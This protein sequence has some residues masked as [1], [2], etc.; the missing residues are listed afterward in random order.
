VGLKY[1]ISKFACTQAYTNLEVMPCSS[2]AANVLTHAN[3]E[4][5]TS[6]MNAIFATEL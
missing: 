5:Q 1:R 2:N 3:L 4:S 6:Q